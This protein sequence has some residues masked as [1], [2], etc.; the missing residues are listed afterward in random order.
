MIQ[1]G[2]KTVLTG[3]LICSVV[4]YYMTKKLFKSDTLKHS[5]SRIVLPD[6]RTVLIL[7]YGEITRESS[8]EIHDKLIEKLNGESFEIKLT[9]NPEN[10]KKFYFEIVDISKYDDLNDMSKEFSPDRRFEMN[11]EDADGFPEEYYGTTMK[12]VAITTIHGD[13]QFLSNLE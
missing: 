6:N 7:D 13:E 3:T 10:P 4:A 11:L 2:Y 1:I 8:R 5:E 9:K 12:C